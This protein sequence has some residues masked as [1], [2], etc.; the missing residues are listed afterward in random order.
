MLIALLKICTYNEL[1]YVSVKANIW[2]IRHHMWHN[3]ETSIFWH[4]ERFTNCLYC[5]ASANIRFIEN[6]IKSMHLKNTKI[7]KFYLLS[8]I[9]FNFKVWILIS[10]MIL[11]VYLYWILIFLFS[12]GL[13]NFFYY[14]E[15]LP[16]EKF[17]AWTSALNPTKLP[18][19]WYCFGRAT[20]SGRE[21]FSNPL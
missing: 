8:I 5:V 9:I 21:L 18:N 6:N 2:K 4:V 1:F 15:R 12:Y 16:A 17:L 20:W 10:T 14:Y 3:F 13:S 7:Y 19:I 11:L